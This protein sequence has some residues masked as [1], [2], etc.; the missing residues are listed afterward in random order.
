MQIITKA[1][2]VIEFRQKIDDFGWELWI[3]MDGADYALEL[4]DEEMKWI[5]LDL[6]KRL[7]I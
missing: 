1:G 2:Q 5:L 4:T 6:Q 3:R 7:S